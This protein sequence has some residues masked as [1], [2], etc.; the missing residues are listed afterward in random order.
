M[1]PLLFIALVLIAD[2][3]YPA[4]SR[5]PAEDGGAN[6]QLQMMLQQANAQNARL[7]ASNAEL[8][9]EVDD[10][11]AELD[12]LE[13]AQKKSAK[14]IRTQKQQL[15]NSSARASALSD[16]NSELRDRLETLSGRYQELAEVLRQVDQQR[17][18]LTTMAQDYEERVTVCQN[19]N[20]DLYTM[21][22]ELSQRYEKKGFFTVLRQREPITGVSKARMEN[23]MD[24]YRRLAEEMRLNYEVSTDES[25]ASE[26]ETPID[27]V[28]GP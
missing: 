12:A 9:R 4:S 1:R 13:A 3:A 28:D 21:V 22:Q 24:E 19:N 2:S 14:S 16:Q 7:T 18:T 10:L 25:S 8:N 17:S 23:Q 6:P 20:E 26:L 5:R 11:R 27:A 15:A